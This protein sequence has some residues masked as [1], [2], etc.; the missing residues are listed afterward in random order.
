MLNFDIAQKLKTLRL[1]NM[2]DGWKAIEKLAIENQE[3]YAWMLDQLCTLE[4]EAREQNRLKRYQSD[5]DLIPTKTMLSL[6]LGLLPGT[7]AQSIMSLVEDTTWVDRANNVLLFGASGLGK[8]HVANAIGHALIANNIRGKFFSATTIVQQ[9]MN[10]KAALKLNEYLLKLDKYAFIVIDDIGYVSRD[11]METS[12]LF[13]LINHRYE[14][15]AIIVTS[16]QSFSEWNRIFPDQSM[17]VAAIDR[18]IHHSHII[19][20]QGESYRKQ[21]AE[22]RE[23]ALGHQS[24]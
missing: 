15:H 16:N 13:E 22:K 14:R 7:T 1:S 21:Y 18:L 12:V 9:L 4:L 24:S 19:E 11:M 17:T 2:A 8:T 6:E 10:A 23:L 5:S 20:L 3:S